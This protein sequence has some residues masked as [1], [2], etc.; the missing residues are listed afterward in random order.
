MQDRMVR[1]ATILLL[2]VC[3]VYV[4]ERTVE[5]KY[6]ASSRGLLYAAVNHL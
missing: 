5:R 3:A 6:L 1:A 2:L 4:G